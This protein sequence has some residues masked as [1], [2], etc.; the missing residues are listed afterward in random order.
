MKATGAGKDGK[1]VIKPY[2][3]ISSNLVTG[4]FD[5]LVKVY[6]NGQASSWAGRLDVGDAVSFKQVKGNV[7]AFRYPFKGISRITMLAGGTGVAPMIQALHPLLETPGETTKVRLIYGNKSPSEI[8]LKS[9]LDRLAAAHSDRFEVIYVV[10]ESEDDDRAVENEGWSGE[11]GWIDAEKVSRLAFPPAE[12][13]AIWV[14]GVDDMYVA[15]AGSRLKP[16]APDSVLAKLG[17]S[18]DMVWRS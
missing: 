2:N 18:E 14:C 12:G 9:E 15:L 6:P 10:G 17:Y 8:M 16:L 11:V 5:L 3:P 7:K 4:S 13:T 1:D